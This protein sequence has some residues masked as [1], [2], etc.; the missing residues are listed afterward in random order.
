M[1]AGRLFD[2]FDDFVKCR[3][4]YDDLGRFDAAQAQKAFE[5]YQRAGKSKGLC[6]GTFR[7]RLGAVR[8]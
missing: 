6:D 1:N 2:S 5:I 4:F 8:R 3:D 7:E